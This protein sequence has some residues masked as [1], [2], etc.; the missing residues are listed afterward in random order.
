MAKKKTKRGS[1]VKPKP[2]KV[3][4][5]VDY[6]KPLKNRKYEAFCQEFMIDSNG[7]QA[8]IRA[9]YSENGANVKGS[10]LLTI[11]SVQNRLAVLRAKLSEE[12]GVDAAMVIEGFRKIATGT[13][14][15]TLT[16]KH[17]LRALENLAKHLGLYIKDN[18]QRR[19]LTL[20]DIAAMAGV[21]RA[22]G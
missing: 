7:A 18:E 1:A 5:P 20:A 4:A 2:K 12:T 21:I 22:N 11:V 9:G 8:A 3:D 10:Q 15:K 19:D 16:N 13:L 6:S 17:K 14:S